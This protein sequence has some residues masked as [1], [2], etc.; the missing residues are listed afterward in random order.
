M[1]RPDEPVRA[2]TLFGAAASLREGMGSHLSPA[3]RPVYERDLALARA[4]CDEAAFTAAREAGHA[5]T[6]E[7]AIAFA[8]DTAVTP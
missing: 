4:L 1:S 3:E 8:R 7:Q 6:P 5:L 2:A